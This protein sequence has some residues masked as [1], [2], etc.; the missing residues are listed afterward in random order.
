VTRGDPTGNHTAGSN[1]SPT[2]RRGASEKIAGRET[3]TRGNPLVE[4]IK[5]AMAQRR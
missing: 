4:K 3:P 5:S 2:R 1:G